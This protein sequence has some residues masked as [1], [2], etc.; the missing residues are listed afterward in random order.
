M[1]TTDLDRQPAATDPLARPA[2]PPPAHEPPRQQPVQ[3]ETGRSSAATVALVVIG[4]AV[5]AF[6]LLIATG[7]IRF[8]VDGEAQAPRIEVSGGSAPEVQVE[9]G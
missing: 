9:V 4:F 2:P 1:N 5:A 3:R 8:N 7:F 6:A